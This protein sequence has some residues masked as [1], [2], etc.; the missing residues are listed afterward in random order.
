MLLI[1]CMDVHTSFCS[2]KVAGQAALD[3]VPWKAIIHTF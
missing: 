1:W 3:G 2:S